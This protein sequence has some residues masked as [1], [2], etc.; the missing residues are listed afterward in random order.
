MSL[1]N[2]KLPR[3]TGFDYSSE[4]S[5]FV[6]ICTKNKKCLFGTV[7][8]LNFYGK[9]AENELLKITTRFKDIHLDKYI[10]MPNHIHAIITIGANRVIRD[11]EAHDDLSVML[12]LYKS[13]VSR[14]IHKLSPGLEIWQKSF[15][16]HII[17][18]ESAYYEI[19][20]YIDENPVRWKYKNPY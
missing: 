17:R 14:E 3:L 4:N 20:R 19:C 1:P 8:A 6:T 18:N 10:I 2:R 9:I 5:Y 11:L 15:Y 16:D 7:D 12:G 13:G